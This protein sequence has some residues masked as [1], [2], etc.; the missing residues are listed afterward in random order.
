MSH[1]EPQVA[2]STLLLYSLSLSIPSS[3]LSLWHTNCSLPFDSYMHA[4]SLPSKEMGRECIEKGEISTPLVAKDEHHQIYG[5]GTSSGDHV[6]ANTTSCDGGGEWV[7]VELDKKESQQCHMI[8][9]V[10]NWS[11]P[12]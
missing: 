3:F 12:V 8:I 9:S 6:C 1:D 4:I 10:F 11:K 5:S 2:P 7:G